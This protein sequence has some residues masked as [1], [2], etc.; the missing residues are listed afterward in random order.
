MVDFHRTEETWLVKYTTL[1][2]EEFKKFINTVENELS[3]GCEFL[4]LVTR[5]LAD[6]AS[7]IPHPF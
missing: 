6:F 1:S 7:R 5:L 3:H 4:P 2:P